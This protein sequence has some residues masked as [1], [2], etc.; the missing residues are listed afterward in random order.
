M[1]WD[2]HFKVISWIASWSEW[3]VGACFYGSAK[4]MQTLGSRAF[5]LLDSVLEPVGW[6]LQ[7]KIWHAFRPIF[8]MRKTL[9]KLALAQNASVSSGPRYRWLCGTCPEPRIEVG[10]LLGTL[11][12]HSSKNL[13]EDMVIDRVSSCLCLHFAAKSVLEGRPAACKPAQNGLPMPF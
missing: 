9:P 6:S 2:L 5:C 3:L 8:Q 7:I 10:L 4:N 11:S 12:S 13:T 1:R